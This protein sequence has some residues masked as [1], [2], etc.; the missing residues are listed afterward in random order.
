MSVCHAAGMLLRPLADSASQ[1]QCWHLRH[2]LISAGLSSS[3]PVDSC[4]PRHLGSQAC[5][6]PSI[7]EIEHVTGFSLDESRRSA[8]EVSLL[9][10]QLPKA[11]ENGEDR[12]C[13][14]AVG[15]INDGV[16]CWQVGWCEPCSPHSC[17]SEP[18]RLDALRPKSC[19]PL[20]MGDCATLS[21]QG[22]SSCKWKPLS[23]TS[24]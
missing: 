21:T 20:T 14:Q 15:V 6:L 17:L 9:T 23:V 18:A 2:Y 24:L 1:C 4:Q 10:S 11:H 19:F 13:S 22:K 5:G 7:Q 12:R 3:F 8:A 16:M